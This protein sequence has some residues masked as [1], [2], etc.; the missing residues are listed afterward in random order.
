MFLLRTSST[1]QKR[2]G[3]KGPPC[4]TSLLQLKYPFNF[5]L[6]EIDRVAECKIVLIQE[7]NL[8]L[9]PNLLRTLRRKF[10]SRVSKAFV[11]ST[12]KAKLPAKALL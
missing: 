7:Q 8:S 11:M 6:T 5:P 1:M 10:H 12:L 4:L 9:K 3:D 2:R